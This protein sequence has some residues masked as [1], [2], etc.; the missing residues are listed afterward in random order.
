M[1]PFSVPCVKRNCLVQVLIKE[2]LGLKENVSTLSAS[3]LL[4][5]STVSRLEDQAA[6]LKA[7][8]A[9]CKA[10]VSVLQALESQLSTNSTGCNSKL[11]SAAM[12]LLGLEAGVI[13]LVL[14]LAC[15]HIGR[16][17]WAKYRDDAFPIDRYLLFI[18]TYI[19]LL[20]G[21]VMVS[22]A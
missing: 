9:H 6:S 10:N 11:E 8:V 2:N 18:Y 1:L 16:P 22:H 14:W 3:N 4:L 20:G 17:L 5:R 13:I 7:E 21:G 15:E 19:F 12:Q